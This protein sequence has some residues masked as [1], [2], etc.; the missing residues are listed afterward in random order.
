MFAPLVL[1][2]LNKLKAQLEKLKGNEIFKTF[3]GKI[4][5]TKK[6]L[7]KIE[8]VI[9]AIQLKE[10]YYKLKDKIEGL[11]IKGKLAKLNEVKDK[12]IEESQKYKDFEIKP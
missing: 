12:S 8:E 3:K 10:V 4:G 9:K 5:D 7:V 1:I 6:E 2:T 11:Y